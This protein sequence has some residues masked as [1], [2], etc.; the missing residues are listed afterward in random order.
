MA[1][2]LRS[3]I[4]CIALINKITNCPLAR[5]NCVTACNNIFHLTN[6]TL[7]LYTLV[8]N[9]VRRNQSCPASYNIIPHAWRTLIDE[10]ESKHPRTSTVQGYVAKNWWQEKVQVSWEQLGYLPSQ[11]AKHLDQIARSITQNSHGRNGQRASNKVAG[12]EVSQYSFR[13][14]WLCTAWAT[15]Q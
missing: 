11:V 1:S 10:H 3:Q 15:K 7:S 9:C 12:I 14:A 5:G 2:S 13:L 8:W 4:K 6:L